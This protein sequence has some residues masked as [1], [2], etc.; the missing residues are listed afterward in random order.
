M[1]ILPPWYYSLYCMRTGYE[2]GS[3]KNT[4]AMIQS[5]NVVKAIPIFLLYLSLGVIIV[6]SKQRKINWS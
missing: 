3:I 5:V 1:V 2:N 4:D 6:A